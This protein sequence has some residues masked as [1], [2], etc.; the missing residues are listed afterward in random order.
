MW[1][2]PRCGAEA[3]RDAFVANLKVCPACGFHTRI[4]ARER[5]AQL[6]DADSFRERFAALRTLDPLDVHRP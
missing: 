6:A 2:C 5:I 3:E 1:T 4:G